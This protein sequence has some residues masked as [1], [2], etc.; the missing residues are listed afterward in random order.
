MQWVQ[1][2]MRSLIREEIQKAMGSSDAGPGVASP[3]G[4]KKGDKFESAIAQLKDQN[5]QQLKVIVMALR[6]AGMEIPLT[7]SGDS[8]V[9]TPTTIPSETVAAR[10][11]PVIVPTVT[12]SAV[13]DRFS[14]HPHKLF[15]RLNLAPHRTS[16]PSI[17]EATRPIRTRRRRCY[18][19]DWKNMVRV[20]FFLLINRC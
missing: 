15:H 5:D 18:R 11:L 3:S 13:T 19:S 7:G 6:K 20:I 2:G 8:F 4:A 16:T 10:V 14:Y 17:Q 12:Y 9:V 1:E